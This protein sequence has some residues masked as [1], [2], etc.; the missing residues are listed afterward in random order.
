MHIIS[1]F[2]FFPFLK[3]GAPSSTLADH[4]QRWS[5]CPT[6]HCLQR[7]RTRDQQKSTEMKMCNSPPLPAPPL[8]SPPSP[9]SNLPRTSSP[10]LLTPCGWIHIAGV[11]CAVNTTLNVIQ[12]G[13]GKQC[14]PMV[15]VGK[16]KGSRRFI[17][18]KGTR[19][20][21]SLA[22]T[23]YYPGYCMWIS[24]RPRVPRGLTVSPK[25]QQHL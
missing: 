1:F 11:G 7:K 20:M 21:I 5:T 10:L 23:D 17:G 16:E 24:G 8:P 18:I 19:S 14:H 3:W 12:V 6:D 2:F 9:P 25:R 22:C 15:G 4:D 13:V